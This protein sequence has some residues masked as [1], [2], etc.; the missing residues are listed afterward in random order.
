MSRRSKMSVRRAKQAEMKWKCIVFGFIRRHMVDQG[1]TVPLLIHYT[2]LHYYWLEEKFILLNPTSLALNENG[3]VVKS[4]VTPM[5]GPSADICD[6]IFGALRIGKEPEGI[7]EY[8]WKISFDGD[9]KENIPNSVCGIG[10]GSTD[11]DFKCLLFCKGQMMKVNGY[12][13]NSMRPESLEKCQLKG[14]DEVTMTL[15]VENRTLHFNVQRVE[16]DSL[17]TLVK[18]ESIEDIQLERV[19]FFVGVIREGH[20]MKLIDFSVLQKGMENV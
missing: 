19:Y 17:V 20:S 14:Q 18:R 8:Q 3:R 16:N 1:I 15:N 4:N 9:H 10:I 2:C 13:A 11:H 5:P 12:G 6:S 7:S